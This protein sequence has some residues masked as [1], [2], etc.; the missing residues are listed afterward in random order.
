MGR[1]SPE[2]RENGTYD[3]MGLTRDYYDL[4]TSFYEY[5]WGDLFHFA[6]LYRDK[7]FIESIR[8]HETYLADRL[9]IRPDMRVLD[10][11][12]GIGAPLV[13]IAQHTGAAIVGLNNNEAQVEKARARAAAANL[14]QPAGFIVGDYMHIDAP[15][16][17]FLTGLMPSSPCRTPQTRLRPLPKSTE[18]LNPGACSHPMT[19]A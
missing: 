18:F 19:G 3:Y 5:G 7:S 12:C 2:E 9:D 17:Q 14:A 13:A 11:G 6:P 16:R 4:V 15:G 1:F 8:L 10:I